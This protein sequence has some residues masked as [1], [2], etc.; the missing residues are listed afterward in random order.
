MNTSESVNV[1][2]RDDWVF[3]SLLGLLIWAPLPL[4]SNRIWAIGILSLWTLVLVLGAL[5]AWRGQVDAALTR[6]RRFAW[7]LGLLAAMVTLT[8]IQTL[9][10]PATLVALLSPEAARVQAQT[11]GGA[12]RLSLDVFQTHTMSMLAFTYFCV[13]LV[14]AL[15]IRNAARL[16]RLALTLVMSGVLQAVLGTV[17]FALKTH[18][19]LF[20]VEI[21][22]SRVIGSYVSQNSLA[23]YLNMCLSM[24]IGLMLARLGPGGRWP[25]GW[26]H[27]LR[28]V[29]EFVLS[30]RMHLRL[31]LVVMVIALV[32]TRSRMG[33]AAFFA[34]MLMVGLTTILLMRR[35][36]PTMIVL[37]ASLVVIDVFIIGTWVGLEQVVQRLEETSLTNASR[38]QEE[39]VEDRTEGGRRAVRIIQDFP[40]VGT[41][42]GSFYGSFMRYREAGEFY[43]DHAH[44]DFIEIAADYGMIGLGLLGALVAMALWRSLSVLARRRSS[45]PRGIAFGV[46]MSIVALLIHSTVDFNLQIPANALTMVVILSLAWV[47]HELPSPRPRHGNPRDAG[48]NRNEFKGETAL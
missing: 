30:S 34:S 4:G 47:C 16:D 36:A 5:F 22:H 19:W 25:S 18:Y 42:G 46:A 41:G 44:N 28:L 8:W 10:L 38:G 9:P 1:V 35:T 37:I 13:F 39:T 24:G 21:A 3:L 23:G 11:G 6:L 43:Y 20:H 27:R 32:L 14:A 33:N 26:K 2:V 7:P 48:G 29:L 40:L 31:M 45:L 12:M 17:L 15:S